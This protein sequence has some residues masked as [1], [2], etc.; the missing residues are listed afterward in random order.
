MDDASA[1]P[2]WRIAG[3]APAAI[4]RENALPATELT[5]GALVGVCRSPVSR[6][7]TFNG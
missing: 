7:F 3:L 2:P 4:A 6:L 1:A 5:M